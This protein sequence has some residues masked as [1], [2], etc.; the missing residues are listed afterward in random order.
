[1]K[2]LKPIKAYMV[3]GPDGKVAETMNAF[4][5]WGG[6]DALSIFNTKAAAMRYA[7][8]DLDQIVPVLIVPAVPKER[9]TRPTA[10]SIPPS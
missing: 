7:S 10:V 3:L 8:K 9:L 5:H 6:N 2:K 1:M 4:N